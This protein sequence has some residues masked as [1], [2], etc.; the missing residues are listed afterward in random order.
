MARNL[1]SATEAAERWASGFGQAGQRWAAG[2][3]AVDTAP[4]QLAVA[5]KPRYLAGVQNNV[6]KWEA[7]T[8]AVTLQAWK[9]AS[10]DVGQGRLSS[11]ATKGK[12]KFQVQIARVLD[13]ERSIIA[14]LPPRGDVSANI[15]RSSAFQMA[16]H[17]AFQG[18]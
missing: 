8:Q 9:Q 10:I 12:G 18:G 1:P 16:M 15:A 11:G 17:Q 14:G 13:A 3:N 5:A 6:G 2:I 7:R 4:G